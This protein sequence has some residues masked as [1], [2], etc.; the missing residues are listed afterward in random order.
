MAV[1]EAIMSLY[2]KETVGLDRLEATVKR[3]GLKSYDGS[4]QASDTEEG[5][6]HWVSFCGEA[7]KERIR[8]EPESEK[9]STYLILI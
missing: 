4:L 6:L 5:L 9:V 3:Y 8:A 7:L 2:I 1:I